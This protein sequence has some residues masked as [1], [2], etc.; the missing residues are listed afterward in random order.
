MHLEGKAFII[1]GG[2]GS[3][4]GT[5]AK[6]IIEKGGIAVVF[7]VLPEEA[8]Q[9]KVKSYHAERAFY[10]KTDIADFEAVAKAAQEALKVIPKGS[11]FGGV[12]CAAIAPGREWTHKLADSVPV[13]EKV[14]KVN[15]YGTFAIDSA[16]ADAINSQ[17]PDEGPF[18]PR[19]KEERGC[20]VNVA[21]VVASPVPA[22]CL[23]YGASKAAVLGITQGMADFLGPFGIRVNA[24]SPA[25]VASGLMGP[26]R[27]PYFLK[28]LEAGVIFPH[29]V[30]SP[31][32]IG[33]GILFLLENSMM[34]DFNLRVDGGWRGSSN[35]GAPEDP[36]KNALALE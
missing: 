32:E 25:V 1:T 14:L 36:R 33:D 16:I 26:D 17:Y 35:W 13:F 19:V 23:T 8:G 24:I 34:N 11:L 7:D 21:S 18:G 4:G 27:L 12:H 30:T 5:A 22:R 20:I 10:F 9:E 15:A 6:K 2:C 29:R 3:I 31:D 28:E